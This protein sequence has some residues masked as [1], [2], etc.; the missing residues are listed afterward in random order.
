MLC[1]GGPGYRY[2]LEER[3]LPRLQYIDKA[4][5]YVGGGTVDE[6]LTSKEVG[7]DVSLPAR[8]VAS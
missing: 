1:I 3:T 6:D 5:F 8:S 7:V 2:L 4:R